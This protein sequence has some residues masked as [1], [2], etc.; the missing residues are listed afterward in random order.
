MRRVGGVPADKCRSDPPEAA[1][2]SRSAGT[3]TGGSSEATRTRMPAS[4]APGSATADMGV[5]LRIPS[6][7]TNRSSIG[8]RE[9][10]GAG[11]TAGAGGAG[12]SGVGTLNASARGASNIAVAAGVSASGAAGAL[13]AESFGAAFVLGL[14]ERN[15][16]SAASPSA[17][18]ANMLA[19]VGEGSFPACGMEIGV[20]NG[21]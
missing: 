11:V 19:R 18:L 5:R 13:N 9:E 15:T 1:K 6:V 12:A 7:G 20:P 17:G 3:S 2:C 14:C 16:A 4:P 8:A 21:M 10:A